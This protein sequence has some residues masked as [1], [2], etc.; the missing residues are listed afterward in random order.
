M[1]IRQGRPRHVDASCRLL[2]LQA[3]KPTL[4]KLFRPRPGLANL[5]ED[6]CSNCGQFSCA[7]P[8]GVLRGKYVLGVFQHHYLLYIVII[9]FYILIRIF[10]KGAI[11]RKRGNQIWLLV[12]VSK[13]S[14]NKYINLYV[15]IYIVTVTTG[16]TEREKIFDSITRMPV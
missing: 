4:F 11:W 8:W 16:V 12:H 9:I 14:R 7:C 6:A 5:G 10:R 15:I 1:N 3:Y 2:I 13:Q